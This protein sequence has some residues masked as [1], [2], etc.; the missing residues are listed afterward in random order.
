M[1]KRVV[2]LM[3]DTGGGHRAAAEAIGEALGQLHG[4]AIQVELVDLLVDY[5]HWPLNR[6]PQ[7][8]RQLVDRYTGLWHLLLA[9][10]ERA[11]LWRGVAAA[12]LAW[13]RLRLQRFF[14][15][16]PADLLVSVHPLLNRVPRQAASRG[17]LRHRGDRPHHRA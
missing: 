4:E 14:R 13:H 1:R 8:Y 16:H 2:F 11:W 17:A 15:A 3:S 7:M 9:A 5:A 6:A 12:S 10:G